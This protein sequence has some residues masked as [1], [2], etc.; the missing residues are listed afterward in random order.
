[1]VNKHIWGNHEDK[2]IRTFQGLEDDCVVMRNIRAMDAKIVWIR[3][4]VYEMV[5]RSETQNHHHR[6]THLTENM[7]SPAQKKKKVKLL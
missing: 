1:M 6:T 3:K 4:Q 5:V 7:H 2:M